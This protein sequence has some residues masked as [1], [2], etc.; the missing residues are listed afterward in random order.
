MRAFGC[1]AIGIV[2]GILIER[3]VEP[4]IVRFVFYSCMGIHL[5]CIGRWS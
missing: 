1:M 4:G 5:I 2:F 3:M